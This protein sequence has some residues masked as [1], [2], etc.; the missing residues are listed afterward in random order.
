MAAA[1][2]TER[3][4]W[5][6]ATMQPMTASSLSIRRVGPTLDDLCIHLG[7]KLFELRCVVRCLVFV[8]H[9]SLLSN[10]CGNISLHSVQQFTTCTLQAAVTSCIPFDSCLHA[11]MIEY[12]S[13]DGC[14]FPEEAVDFST[15]MDTDLYALPKAKATAQ[16]LDISADG[17]Q[18]AIW[19]S[20]RCSMVHCVVDK[21]TH[22]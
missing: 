6:C 4:L 8:M 21:H 10:W 11:G 18:F 1:K 14:G 19:S 17:S 13:A 5:Q 20:D 12:W 16:S 2:C 7:H 3:L 22:G 15:K 9:P